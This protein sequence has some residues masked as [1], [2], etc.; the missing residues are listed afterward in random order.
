MTKIERVRAVL[1]GRRPDRPPVSFWCHFA[2]EQV[3]GRAAVDAHMTHL[4]TF[5][6]DFLKVMNDNPYP[7]TAGPAVIHSVDDLKAIHV[8]DG[9]EDGF[10]RQLDVVRELAGRRR[11]DIV[12]CSTLFNAWAT[13]RNWIQPP[14]MQHGPPKMTDLDERDD[15]LTRLLREDR[16]A[17]A[18]AL[19]TIAASLGNFAGECIKAGAD[20]VFLSVRDDW[21]DRAEN[22][23]GTYDAIVRPT[24][25]AILGAASAGTFNMLHVCGKAVD[26]DRFAGYP[27]HVLNWADRAAGPSLANACTRVKPAIAGGVDNLK[28]LPAGTPDQVAAQVRDALRQAGDRPILITPGCTYDP[29]VVPAE[30][31]RAMVEAAGRL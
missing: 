23:V 17:V 22:G 12:F 29:A 16:A 24:D 4:E 19:K 1:E 14:R 6:L 18:G 8:L 15:V 20:G 2:P 10:G 25:L 13:L 31:L 30:N 28:E 26:F 21:V 5:D 9:T 11:G 27:V 7:R 3:A